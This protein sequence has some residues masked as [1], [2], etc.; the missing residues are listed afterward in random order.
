MPAVN[1]VIIGQNL[2]E[3]A[4]IDAFETWTEEDINDAHW[5]DQFRNMSKWP[6]DNETRRKNREVVTSPRDIYDLGELYKSGIKSYRFE[7][8]S[9]GAEANWHWD[10][11]NSSDQEYAWYVHNGEGTNVT[12]R[13]FTDDIS[14]PSSFFFKT[15]GKALKLRVTQYLDRLNAS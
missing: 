10:A 14:I 6:Y 11:K 3:K 2:I 4:L 13:P 8:S 7:R 9:N 12:A 5:D 1:A 15:P